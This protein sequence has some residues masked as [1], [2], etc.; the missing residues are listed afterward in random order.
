M[1]SLVIDI[2][3]RACRRDRLPRSSGSSIRRIGASCR[4]V[5]LGF[6]AT[7]KTGITAARDTKHRAHGPHLK[8]N[9]LA[10]AT[11]VLATGCCGIFLDVGFVTVAC[12]LGMIAIG[13]VRGTS[14]AASV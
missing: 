12:I 13:M 9:L 6:T 1:H 2:E 14:I 11:A 7:D 10:T 3:D 5:V 4:R 8:A